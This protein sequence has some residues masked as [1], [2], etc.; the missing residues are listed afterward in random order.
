[1]ITPPSNTTSGSWQQQQ[2]VPPQA[3][4]QHHVTATNVNSRGTSNIGNRAARGKSRGQKT[5]RSCWTCGDPS[6]WTRTC[7]FRQSQPEVLDGKVN[8][9]GADQQNS[10]K[11]TCGAINTRS[12]SQLLVEIYLA[13]NIDGKRVPALLDTGCERSVCGIS[14][15]PPGVVIRENDI[16]LYAANGSSIDVSGIATLTFLINNRQF[17]MDVLISTD[18]SEIIFGSDFLMDYDGHWSFRKATLWLGRLRVRI[19]RKPARANVRR[20]YAVEP[21]RISPNSEQNVPVKLV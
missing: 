20:I 18:I 6:H 13:I 2:N 10:D 11:S 16:K 3:P 12:K 8:V 14:Q 15:L 7:P 19:W 17:E 21:I 9:N 4:Y 5:D 1:M